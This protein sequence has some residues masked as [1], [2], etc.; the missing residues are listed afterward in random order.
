M[1]GVPGD[2]V[3][4]AAACIRRPLGDNQTVTIDG[5]AMGFL[6]RILLSAVI[7]AAPVYAADITAKQLIERGEAKFAKKDLEGALADFRLAI[8]VDPNDWEAYNNVGVVL[9][10]LGRPEKGLPYVLKSIRLTPN[11]AYPL[12]EISQIYSKLKRFDDAVD[13]ANRAIR[14]EPQN[15]KA[16][17]NRGAAYSWLGKRSRAMADYK[18]AIQLN[19]KYKKAR[20]DLRAIRNR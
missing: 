6:I 11:N 18:M 12:V 8:K 14:L 17:N 20:D 16:Y 15:A 9:S 5:V 4:V 10:V 2:R 13:A 19:L 3:D 1:R 7:L